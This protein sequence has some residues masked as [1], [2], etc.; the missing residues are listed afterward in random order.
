MMIPM[1]YAAFYLGV[2]L[3][4]GAAVL[5][6]GYGM[7]PRDQ[8]LLYWSRRLLLGALLAHIAVS[9]LR[10]ATWG[11]AP[12][13]S[14]ADSLNLFIILVSLTSFVLS[15]CDRRLSLLVFYAPACALLSLVAVLVTLNSLGV[16]PRSLPVL[17]TAVHVGLAFLAYALFFVASL[18]G[19]A[20]AYV[21]R[22]LKRLSTVG[23]AQKLPSLENLDRTL[24]MLISFGYPVF[25]I[26][27]VL[28]V[29]WA[30]Y[31]AGTLTA[32]W[33]WSP[34]IIWSAVMVLFYAV[35]FHARSLGLLRGP[36]LAH[37]IC[38]GFALL[39]GIYLVLELFHLLNYNFYR[40]SA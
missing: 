38:V 14:V 28:G 25:V 24:Y 6:L 10:L 40:V 11:V 8:R 33:W 4:L 36:K 26:T 7:T 21:A 27:L 19:A 29:A 32:N 30:W 12:I 18:T 15:C 3:H 17:L 2:A 16:A 23:L 1:V 13:A 22:S 35:S 20:Y 37:L 31:D 5:A 39:L 9:G 34:K